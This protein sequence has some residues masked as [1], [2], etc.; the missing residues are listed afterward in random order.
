M[1]AKTGRKEK[2]RENTKKREEIMKKEKKTE[3]EEKQKEKKKRHKREGRSLTLGSG[4][5]CRSSRAL[6]MSTRALL[7][8][9][10]KSSFFIAHLLWMKVLFPNS[11]RAEM[12]ALR[13]GTAHECQKNYDFSESLR[14]SWYA[15][16]FFML[17]KEEA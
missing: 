3:A 13:K 5:C 1:Y 10:N 8:P 2:R 7:V 11:W 12:S 16:V 17:S 4:I 14:W 9:K 15:L 6:V